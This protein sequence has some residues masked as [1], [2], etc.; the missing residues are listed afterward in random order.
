ML[1]EYQELIK[2]EG[3]SGIQFGAKRVKTS[4]IEAKERI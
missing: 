4:T 3:V 1:E 2:G